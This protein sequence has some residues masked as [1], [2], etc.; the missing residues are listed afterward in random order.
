MPAPQATTGTDRETTI[1]KLAVP[2]K[3]S[4]EDA[5]MLYDAL[6]G[7]PNPSMPWSTVDAGMAAIM[8]DNG[9]LL[10]ATSKYGWLKPD[11]TLLAC[12]QQAHDRLLHCL[13]M[14]TALA[15]VAGWARVTTHGVRS[16]HRLTGSQRAAVRRLRVAFDDEADR[17]KPRLGSGDGVAGYADLAM[18]D[19]ETR[20]R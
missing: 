18:R 14:E 3:R 7:K 20:R 8:I 17:V 19:P 11:G 6:A 15:E 2:R 10:D 9:R 4:R 1:A 5:E 13:G 16:T 12:G